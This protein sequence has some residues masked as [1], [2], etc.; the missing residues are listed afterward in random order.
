[1]ILVLYLFFF[2]F[3]S[4][5]GE[6]K[7]SCLH[8]FQKLG[9][10]SQDRRRL[11]SFSF[12]TFTLPTLVNTPMQCGN[13][14]NLCMKTK[15]TAKKIQ[16]SKEINSLH[17][18][19]ASLNDQRKPSGTSWS[20]QENF[21]D[22]SI[23]SNKAPWAYSYIWSHRHPRTVGTITNVTVVLGFPLSFGHLWSVIG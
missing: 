6:G 15:W 16:L 5:V 21:H 23:H 8:R 2:L 19:Y 20:T 11:C 12:V 1:M 17:V 18:Y 4:L 3:F 9:G 10:V 14:W 13:L 22:N 7:N